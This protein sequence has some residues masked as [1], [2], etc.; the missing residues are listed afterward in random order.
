[1]SSKKV[2]ILTGDYV[3]DYEIMV[4]FQVLQMVG[5]TVHVV[6]PGKKVGD[7]IRTAIHDFEGDQ[8]FSEK[9]G[10]NFTINKEFDNIK[11]EDYD[12]LVIPGGR[13]PEYIRLNNKVI[14]IVKHFINTNKPIATICHGPQV[15]IAANAIK[16]KKC[17]ACPSIE[18]DITA[19]GGK[20]IDIPEDQA[21]V[22]NNLV[23]APGWTALSKWLSEF[24][25]LLGTTIITLDI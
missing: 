13:A 4:P 6:C 22:E 7:K 1:M 15:L 3:E 12:A 23:T 24:L 9:I 5:H 16:G 10:H 11:A 8:T 20:Y 19:A 17:S 25:K 14:E 18:P 2:L 21:I